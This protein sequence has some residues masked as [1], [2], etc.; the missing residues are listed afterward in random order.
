MEEVHKID[1]F[2]NDSIQLAVEKLSKSHT[3]KLIG[4][5]ECRVEVDIDVNDEVIEFNLIIKF[6]DFP[7][8][9]PKIFIASQD[10]FKV[11]GIP[12][13]D[14]NGFICTYDNANIQTNMLMPAEILDVCICKAKNIIKTGLES[15]NEQDYEKE[16]NAYWNDYGQS[17][18]P[19][20]STLDHSIN[21]PKQIR[22]YVLD[23]KFNGYNFVLTAE[24]SF[25]AQLI[26]KVKS[27]SNFK[28]YI[29]FYVGE[30]MGIGPLFVNKNYSTIDLIRKNNPKILPQLEVYINSTDHPILIFCK[31]ISNKNLYL[32]WQYLTLK[33]KN[34]FFPSKLSNYEILS[35]PFYLYKSQLNVTRLIPDVYTNERL[36]S[37]SSDDQIITDLSIAM[38]GVGSIGSNLIPLLKNININKFRFVDTEN[39]EIENLGRHLLGINYRGENKAVAMK[40]Y[41]ELKNPYYDIQVSTNSIVDIVSTD[42]QFLAPCDYIFV[43]IGHTNIEYFIDMALKEGLIKRPIFFLWVEPYV[44]G[45]HCV[46]LTPNSLTNFKDLFKN[47]F[48]KNNIILEDDYRNKIF[49]KQESGCQTSFLPYSGLNVMKF[50]CSLYPRICNIIENKISIGKSFTW[51][52]DKKYLKL[53]DINISNFGNENES[54]DILEQDLK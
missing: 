6:I 23:K 18:I 4:N 3:L 29:A 14:I 15:N 27:S 13:I 30:I 17:K 39:L 46:Y 33:K 32:G 50:L 7:L 20:L 2:I 19:V 24:C 51:I 43:C 1:N 21:N 9:I 48:F 8:S 54:E 47:S 52:G 37:R 16:F 25:S 28:E 34:I 10:L 36:I 5:N 44:A 49:S 11:H 38:V 45:G 12:H 31:K 22:L 42:I 35:I 40:N 26:D 53:K 41:L